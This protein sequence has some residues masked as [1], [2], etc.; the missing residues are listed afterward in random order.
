MRNS[1]YHLT[2]VVGKQLG[3]QIDTVL[4]STADNFDHLVKL[5]KLDPQCDFRHA[6]LQAVNFSNSS[7]LGFDFTGADLRGAI[8]TN[9]RWDAT[10]KLDNADLT[11]S[12][13]ASQTRI[14][15]FLRSN[16]DAASRYARLVGQYWTDQVV[17]VAEN[18]KRSRDRTESLFLTE[19][20]L[21]SVNDETLKSQ[22]LYFLLPHKTNDEVKEIFFSSLSQSKLSA[23]YVRQVLRII[24]SRNLGSDAAIRS[25]LDILTHSKD[26][27][28]S[29]AA[30]EFL[31]RNRPE[32]SEI[33]TLSGRITQWDSFTRKF[34]ISEIAKRLGQDFDL[35]TRDPGTNETFDVGA[36]ISGETLF[37]IARRWSRALAQTDARDIPLI[38][39]RGTSVRVIPGE[40][41]QRVSDIVQRLKV[42]QKFGIE[43]DVDPNLKISEE[44]SLSAVDRTHSYFNVGKD[45]C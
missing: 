40:T 33:S 16:K 25:S 19:A 43:F 18:L 7:L 29:T 9:V 30:I 6:N 28:I 10:T 32:D 14:N 12:M 17:W 35:I 31:M 38:Q 26:P 1:G 39:R 11:G 27:W 13:F 34:F 45:S 41:A 22:I 23:E 24:K 5:T 4:E 20:L 44:L 37:L 3:M 21:Y 15:N 2:D 42:L 8:G 36:R